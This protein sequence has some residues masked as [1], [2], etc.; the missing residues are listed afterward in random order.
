MKY[1]WCANRIS[2]SIKISSGQLQLICDH[3]YLWDNDVNRRGSLAGR[4]DEIEGMYNTDYNGH[5]GPYIYV[6]IDHPDD[7]SQTRAKVIQLINDFTVHAI[8]TL[9]FPPSDEDDE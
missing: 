5:F 7:T 8:L 6:N 3:E 1:E 9:I 2:Y 4:I